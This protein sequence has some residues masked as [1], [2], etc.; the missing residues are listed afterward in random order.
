M[1]GFVYKDTPIFSIDPGHLQL[2][3]IIIENV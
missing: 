1:I 2:A 3:L